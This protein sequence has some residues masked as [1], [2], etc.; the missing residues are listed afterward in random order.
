MPE[1]TQMGPLR[2]F[3]ATR[4]V[5][6]AFIA[7]LTCTC[8][9]TRCVCTKKGLARIDAV[10]E[11][12]RASLNPMRLA[13][14][15]A[16]HKIASRTSQNL[17]I[18]HHVTYPC[19]RRTAALVSCSSRLH[20]ARPALPSL[21]AVARPHIVP[22]ATEAPTS[23]SH[24]L[25]YAFLAFITGLGTLGSWANPSNAASVGVRR[26]LEFS[27]PATLTIR[28][29]GSRLVKIY[30]LNYDG[31]VHLMR[32]QPSM[33]T[34]SFPL[35]PGDQ[36]LFAYIEPFTS[37][38]VD[39]YSVR[40]SLRGMRINGVHVAWLHQSQHMALCTTRQACTFC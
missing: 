5:H 35:A 21:A 6:S 25:R 13:K 24:L 22:H 2:H 17:S 28:N 23:R 16:T 19:I 3:G 8:V 9:T 40:Q 18:R 27:Q 26:S 15:S 7:C 31:T 14:Q 34:S 29:D 33:P 1:S 38:T 12:S 32:W 4:H 11:H 39:T 36:E 20:P 10:C 37:W 30:W